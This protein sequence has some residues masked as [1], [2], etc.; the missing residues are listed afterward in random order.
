MKPAN[1]FRW[2]ASTI[3]LTLV[4]ALLWSYLLYSGT[5]GIIWP[6]FGICNQLM[7][8]IGLM[9]ATSYIIKKLHPIY[10][11]V[12]FWLVFIFSLASIYGSYIKI[13][14][15]LLPLGT[16]SAY[17]QASILA[18]FSL[19]FILTLIDASRSY[20]KVIKKISYAQNSSKV[21]E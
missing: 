21:I 8:C 15:E 20:V 12:T 16:F 6:T 18:L 17:L 11:F 14:K 19:L 4:M 3:L 13:T 7:A 2:W 9:V 5:I 1:S 10:G